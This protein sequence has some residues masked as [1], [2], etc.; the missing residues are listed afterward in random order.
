MTRFGRDIAVAGGATAL[1]FVVRFALDRWLQADAPFL[2]FTLSVMGSALLRGLSAGVVAGVLGA[3]CAGA[4][5]AAPHA[6]QGPGNLW[7]HGLLFLLVSVAISGLVHVMLQARQAAE[8]SEQYLGRILESA[9]DGIL[10]FDRD[11]YI[12]FANPAAGAVFGLTQGHMI[13]RVQ[14]DAGW[15]FAWPDGRPIAAAELPVARALRTGE[16]LRGCRLMVRG[17]DDLP[18]QVSVNVALLRDKDGVA[19]GAVVSLTDLT[20]RGRADVAEA[21]A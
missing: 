3:I 13:G 15:G 20:E 11:G 18:R 9:E 7:L 16:A 14:D 8:V 5:F 17:A 10:V 21:V 2:L 4:F 12:T 19:T 6:G 1:V